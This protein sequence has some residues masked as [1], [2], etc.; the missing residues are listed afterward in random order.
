MAAR[1]PRRCLPEFTL[2]PLF[3]GFRKRVAAEIN[4][5]I[6]ES[7]EAAKGGCTKPGPRT[8]THDFQGLKLFPVDLVRSELKRATAV[9]AD[10][11]R[12][13]QPRVFRIN[14][15]PKALIGCNGATTFDFYHSQFRRDCS[16]TRQRDV[17]L[18]S[19]LPA[20]AEQPS[21]SQATGNPAIFAPIMNDRCGQ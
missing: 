9:F 16:T 11:T 1:V 2:P 21:G 4:L 6:I 17:Q 8:P 3:A 7:Y 12:F 13:R 19:I 20:S 18:R 5:E 10:I 15:L 14:A